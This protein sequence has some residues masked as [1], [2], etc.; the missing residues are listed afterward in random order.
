M[1]FIT[2]SLLAAM[3]MSTT[4]IAQQ[5][6]QPQQPDQQ[7]NQQVEPGQQTVPPDQGAGTG[8][9]VGDGEVGPVQP[10]SDLGLGLTKPPQTGGEVPQIRQGN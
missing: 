4:A 3:L 8:A 10:P 5:V 9:G 1:R 2:A 6:Q 7:P